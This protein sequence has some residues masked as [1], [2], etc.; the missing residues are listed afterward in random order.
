MRKTGLSDTQTMQLNYWADFSSL[1]KKKK[2]PLSGHGRPAH[3]PSW[4]KFPSLGNGC[5]LAVGMNTIAYRLHAELY[6][7]GDNAK[8]F[9]CLLREQRRSIE[10]ELGYALAWEEKPGRKKI[11]IFVGLNDADPHDRKDWPRQHQWLAER[12]NDIYR[13]FYGRVQALDAGG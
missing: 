8:P 11:R 7:D 5:R 2:S 6:N 9:F 13:V 3:R 1:L 12:L 10:R 4:M